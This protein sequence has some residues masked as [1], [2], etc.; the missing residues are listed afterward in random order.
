MALSG[1]ILPS[2]ST[3]AN[4]WEKCWENR[5]KSEMDKAAHSSCSMAVQNMDIYFPRKD[6]EDLSNFLDLEFILA[7]TTGSDSLNPI[8]PAGDY[9]ITSTEPSSLYQTGNS[10]GSYSVPEQSSAPP[11]YSTS[12]MEELLRTEVDSSYC[13]TNNVHGRFLVASTNSFANQ[14]FVDNIKVEPS[15]DGYGPIM[16]MVPQSGV[17]I[18]QEGNSSCMMAF[19]QPRLASSPHATGNMTPP[20]S[21]DDLMNTDC[22]PQMCH[23]MTFQ[24]GYHS[25][26]NFPPPP[27]GMQ[28][29]YQT[30]HQFSIYEDG[31]SLHPPAQRVLLTPPSSPLEL[32]D[33]K[34][35]RG[36]RSW[37]RKR[38]ASHT[39]TYAGC[40]KTYTK[41]SHLKAHHRTHT[42]EKPYHCSWEGCGWKFARSDELTRHFRKH[43]GHRPFQCHLCER[44][45]SRSDHLALHMKR[46]M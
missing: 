24:Q 5:W 46:H 21:P 36:R 10:T 13:L 12:L 37:P 15:M 26:Q 38:T 44:A 27:P 40:G 1:T 6:D 43:T 31:L 22:Q 11:P 34:P 8:A 20:L 7:N 16:G 3:F 14:D 45:F 17:K 30:A 25:A 39:C 23:S 29:Q 28:L 2:I 4:P 19:E 18:K 9:P 33:S 41:S 32:L 42:G 35:K